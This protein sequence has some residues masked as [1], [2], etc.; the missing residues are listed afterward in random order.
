MF[1]FYIGEV[2]RRN[3]GNVSWGWAISDGER[4][5]ALCENSTGNPLCYPIQKVQKRIENGSED[6]VLVYYHALVEY[7]KAPDAGR[8]AFLYQYSCMS[9]SLSV[10]S[11]LSYYS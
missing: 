1:G 2:F 6:N 3:H 11:S 5:Y 9:L 4:V 8:A 10:R 7:A